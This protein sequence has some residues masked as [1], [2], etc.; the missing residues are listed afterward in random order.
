MATSPYLGLLLRGPFAFE[1]R[2]NGACDYDV[3][4]NF[5]TIDSAIGSRN[6][7][8]S[9]D[10]TGKVS[11]AQLPPTG[12][13][14]PPTKAVYVDNSRADSYTPDGSLLKPFKAIMAAVNQIAANA[15]NATFSY[16]V[17]LAPG[18][19]AETISLSNPNLVNLTFIGYGVTINPGSN[20]HG[21]EAINNDSLTDVKFVG[22]RFIVN[23][24]SDGHAFNF[25]S[26]TNGTNFLTWHWRAVDS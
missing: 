6:G 10:S 9:L 14:P 18:T 8:A 3:D 21:A 13:T 26:T 24:G 5:Q 11:A 23:S 16:V 20:G 4:L 25:S 12:F 22:M 7:I 19:Y 2:S 17:L 1:R 15:D